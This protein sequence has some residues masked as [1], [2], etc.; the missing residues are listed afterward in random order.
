MKGA[1]LL[2]QV[3]SIV[4]DAKIKTEAG[5][6]VRFVMDHQRDDGSWE[7]SV[8][9]KGGWTDNYHT[10][11]IL[12]CLEEDIRGCDETE[13]DDRLAHGYRFYVG[14]VFSSAGRPALD[15]ASLFSSDCT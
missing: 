5:L 1:R 3:Y 13:H 12:D 6:A 14:H 10:G 11:Y 8:A 2:A 15:S 7:Y 4:N 9:N